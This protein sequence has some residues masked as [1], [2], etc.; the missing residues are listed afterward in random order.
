MKTIYKYPFEIKDVVELRMQKGA[1]LLSVQDQKGA[2]CA[3]ALVDPTAE[4]ENR[5]LRIFG[6]GH[7]V[8]EEELVNLEYFTTFQMHYDRGDLVW[9]V[10]TYKEN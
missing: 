3:W 5:K 2:A 6:T 4:L 8:P 1:K 10:F 7:P 9:H